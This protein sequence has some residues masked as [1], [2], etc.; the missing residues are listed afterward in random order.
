MS[1]GVLLHRP[2]HARLFTEMNNVAG[3]ESTR[4][5]LAGKE[6]LTARCGRWLGGAK[7]GL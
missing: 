2:L 4:D 3:Q 5:G 7:G 1:V 6:R